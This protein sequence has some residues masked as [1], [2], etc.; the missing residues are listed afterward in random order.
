MSSAEIDN[1]SGEGKTKFYE[2]YFS[3]HP[4]VNIVV[5]YQALKN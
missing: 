1:I 4:N 5:C 3:S 2:C